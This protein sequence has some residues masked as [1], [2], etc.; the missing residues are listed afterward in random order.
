MIDLT[1]EGIAAI[2][3]ISITGSSSLYATYR[4]MRSD[5]ISDKRQAA[6]DA[7]K[8]AL[9]AALLRQQNGLLLVAQKQDA[10][11]AALSDV[12]KVVAGV[13]VNVAKVELATNSM[14]DALVKTTALA[15]LLTGRSEGVAAEKKRTG[16]TDMAMPPNAPTPQDISAASTARD[17]A[18][19]N[20][21][22]ARIKEHE[23][24][25]KP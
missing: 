15:N 13:Q 20:D 25:P 24:M 5:R 14:K 8:D 19:A 3:A 1:G 2:I 10:T 9:D 6:A 16:T 18:K 23:T 17:V 21:T 7:Q 22:Q 12:V 11:H 4:Q